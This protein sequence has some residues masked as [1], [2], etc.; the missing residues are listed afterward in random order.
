MLLRPFGAGHGRPG[1]RVRGGDPAQHGAHAGLQQLATGG[2]DEVVV[3]AR[4]QADDHVHL[5]PPRG[6]DDDRHLRERP[7][8]AA[9]LQPADAGQHEVEQHQ[10]GI[11][12]LQREQSVLAGGGGLGL[13]PAATQ[14]EHDAPTDRRVVL[15]EQNA[16]HGSFRAFRELRPFFL[17]PGEENMTAP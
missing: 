11:E 7:D 2:F 13:V 15:D 17:I 16:S 6:E 1:L 12:V 8:P 4:L 9:H 5:L 14:R 10:V 3:G